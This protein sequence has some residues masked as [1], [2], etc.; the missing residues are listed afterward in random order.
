MRGAPVRGGAVRCRC[1]CSAWRASTSCLSTSRR[2]SRCGLPLALQPFDRARRPTRAAP[3]FRRGASR[4]AR[5]WPPMRCSDCSSDASAG[6]LRFDR[7]RH[8]VRVLA[9]PRARSCALPRA[10]RAARG[11]RC[12][13]SG[14]AVRARSCCATAASSRPRASRACSR[15]A[16]SLRSSSSSS[17]AMRF[18]RSRA[19]SMRPRWLCSWP[20]SLGEAAVRGV[21]LALRVVARLLGL[22]RVALAGRRRLDVRARSRVRSRRVRCFSFAD[23][24]LAREHADLRAGAAHDAREPSAP[25][26]SPAGVMTDSPSAEPRRSSRASSSDRAVRTRASMRARPQPDRCTTRGQRAVRCAASASAAARHQREIGAFE[27]RECVGQR[28]RGSSTS[29]ASSQPSST[30]STARSQPASTCSTSPSAARIAEPRALQPFLRGRAA[31]RRAPRA[32]ALRA[33]ASRPRDAFELAALRARAPRAARARVRAADSA[34][35]RRSSS[36]R[37]S[38]S[39]CCCAVGAALSSAASACAELI[40]VRRACA[41]LR[42]RSRRWSACSSCAIEIVDARALDLGRLRRLRGH[43]GVRVPLRL[44]FAEL[45]LGDAQRLRRRASSA[46]RS[47]PAAARLRRAA[48][49]SSSKRARSSRD[50]RGELGVRALGFLARALQLLGQF[51]V[52]LDLLLDARDLGADA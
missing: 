2:W 1:S 31:S 15:S 22:E 35:A 5:S 9:R 19:P 38:A 29:T 26:H 30:V 32:A 47:S 43:A 12:R 10:L 41:R 48:L 6:A 40:E 25:S 3:R 39:T 51:L 36:V 14:G 33:S 27:R 42:A 8:L 17:R 46:A 37:V 18:M 49:R 16:A 24:A 4:A 7:Q 45:R 11:A 34:A 50:V 23:L 28:C 21:D 20:A 44:P 13:A 52:V